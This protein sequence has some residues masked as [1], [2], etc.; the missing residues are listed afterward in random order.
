[1]AVHAATVQVST[2]GDAHIVDITRDVA[3]RISDSGLSAGIACV[4]VPGATGAVT[5]IEYEP[6]CVKDFQRLF[7][8]IVPAAQKYAHHE[9]WGDDNGHSHARAALLGPSLALPFRDGKPCLGTW[10][11]IIFVDFDTRPRDRELV[12][13]LVG[14]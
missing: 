3:Q 1:M 12:L 10:Q 7:D 2:K 14:E 5:T 8:Q 11:Q 13:Q 4:F 6:G 9:T